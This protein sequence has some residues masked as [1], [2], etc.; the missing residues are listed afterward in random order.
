MIVE[1]NGKFQY[2]TPIDSTVTIVAESQ[3]IPMLI[4]LEISKF[5]VSIPIHVNLNIKVRNLKIKDRNLHIIADVNGK[6]NIELPILM[7][8]FTKIGF[9]KDYVLNTLIAYLKQYNFSG[10]IKFDGQKIQIT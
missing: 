3:E 10:T 6:S 9:I 8:P 5:F 1:I 7:H 2:K 4:K